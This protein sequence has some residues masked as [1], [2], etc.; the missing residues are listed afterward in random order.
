MRFKNFLEKNNAG[1]SYIELTV[2]DDNVLISIYVERQSLDEGKVYNL[3]KGDTVRYD[4]GNMNTK[5][6]D[7]LHF[8]HNG[9]QLYA[10]NRDGTAHDK[11]HGYKISNRH[12]EI[13]SNKFGFSLPKNNIIE[14]CPLAIETILLCENFL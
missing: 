12:A 3:G 9:S 5:T 11:S 10:I 14:S 1:T 4:S 8:Y 6:Q 2:F 7:H 13:V